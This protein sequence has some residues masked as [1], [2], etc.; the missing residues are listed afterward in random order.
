MADK[1]VLDSRDKQTSKDV[2]GSDNLIPLSPQWVLQKSGENKPGNVTGENNFTV[3]PGYTS[4][5]DGMKSPGNCEEIHDIPKKKDVFRPTVLDMDSGRRD[6]WRDEERDTNFS[7]RRDRWSEGDKDLGDSRKVDRRMDNSSARNFTE[8]R[9]APSDRWTDV[10]NREANH[11]QRRE[12][13][14][15]T[16]WGPDDKEV[17]SLRDKWMDSSR[18]ADIPIVK[19]LSHLTNHGKDEK[20]GDY[21][22]PWRPNAHNRG[23]VEP[24]PHPC[25]TPSRQGS[26]FAYGRGRGENVLPTS[27]YGRGRVGPGGSP[28]NSTSVHPQSFGT[29]SEKGEIGH[30]E[31]SPISYSRTKLLDV[32]RMTDMISCQKIL[33]GVV[34]VPSLTQEE[35]LEP[36]A[37]CAPTADEVVI[38]KGI[39]KGDIVSSEAPQIHKDGSIGRNSNDFVQGRLAKLGSTEDVPPTVDDYK[40]E[41]VD[42][43]KGGHSNQTEGLSYAKQMHSYRP[44]AKVETMQSQQMYSDRKLYPEALREDGARYRTDEA[45]VNRESSVQGNSSIHPGTAWR[46]PS[47]GERT[48]VTSHDRRE[49]PTDVRSRTS[50]IVWLQ[51]QKNLN[52]EWGSGVADLSYPKD[53]SKWQYGEDLITRMKPSA[54]LDRE[55]DTQKLSQPSPEDLLLYYKDPRGEVQGPFTGSDIIGWF[56]AGYFG[57]DL[58]VRLANAPLDSPFSLLGDVMPHL[59]AKTRP[60]PGFS[61]PKQ[62]EIVHESSSS[63]FSA[64]GQ[65]HTSSSEMDMMKAEQ[66]YKHSSAMEAEN[67]FLESLMSGS[68]NPTSNSPLEKFSFTEG[69]QGYSSGIPP[70][71]VESGDNPYLLAK[72]MALEQQRSLPNSYPYWPGRDATPVVPNVDIVHNSITPHSQLLSS[73]G[74]NPRQQPHPQ[75]L[76]S[77]LQGLPDRS[78]SGFNNGGSGRSN[79]SVLGESD[80]LQEKLE[81]HQSQN[82]PPNA[83]FGVQ[84]Q[85]LQPQ[86]QPS[87]TN[88]LAQNLDN[89]SG[90]LTP[91]KLLSSGLSQ[92]PQLLS[93]L[94]QQ[95]LLQL[96]SQAPV[97]S[98]QMSLLDKL[99]LLKQQQK[100][101]EQQQLLRQQQ[102]LLS[103]VLSDHHLHQSFGDQS[104][105]QLQASALPTGNASADHPRLQP[106]QELFQMGSQT[107]VANLQDDHTSNFVNLPPSVLP[108]V[109]HNVGS[110]PASIKLPH[111]MFANTIYKNS[112]GADIQQNNSLLTT[113]ID[114]SLQSELV[115]KSPLEQISQNRLRFNEHVTKSEASVEFVPSEHPGKSVVLESERNFENDV[116]VPEQV[117]ELMFPLTGDLE[118]AQDE[119]E[120]GSEETS[121]V[122]EPK[123][124]EA[125]E[126]RK[127]SEKK[128]KKQRSSKAQSSDQAKGVSETPSLQQSKPSETEVSN[129]ADRKNEMHIGPGE[130]IHGTSPREATES[131]SEVNMVEIGDAQHVL[132]KGA[133]RDGCESVDAK[134]DSRSV[135]DASQLNTQVTGQRAWKPA[136]G[137]KPKSLLDIQQEEQ[138]KAQTEMAISEI[139]TSVDSINFSTPWAGVVYSDHKTDTGSAELSLGKPDSS[140]NKNSKKSQLD[141]LLAEE[142]S[143]KSKERDM[144]VRNSISLS[145][146]NAQLDPVDDDNF[147]EAKDTKKSRKKSAKAKAVAAKAA[148]PTASADVYVGP[149][150]NEKGKGSRQVQ[151]EKEVLPAVPS[152]P[153][154]GDFVIWKGESVNPPPSPAW[155]ADSGKLSK[156][157]SLRDILREQEKK[158]SSVQQQIPIPTKKS[159]PTQ[160]SRESGPSWSLSASSPTKAV[161]PIQIASAQPK[162]KGDDDLFWGPLDQPK[163]D[164]KQSEFPHL[165]SQGSLGSKSSP[166]KGTFGGSLSRQKSTASRPAERYLS[167]SPAS[168]QPSL[169]EKKHAV[170]KHSE[171]MDFRDWCESETVRLT[172]TKDTSFLEFCLKQSRSEAEILLTENLS[173]YDPAHEFIDKF[174][175]YK[176]LLP[177]DVLEIA[178]Q[179][180][181]DRKATTVFGARDM[182]SENAGV[183]ESSYQVN[184]MGVDG[185]KGGGKKKGKKGKKVSPSVL[186]FNVVSNRIMMGEIQT[187]ED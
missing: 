18:D 109:S 11:D 71:G 181:N 3:S 157:A 103:Q 117:N 91:E 17:D 112:L 23:R 27:L 81:L 9:R 125:H 63:N 12:S 90:I 86:N 161:S 66:R 179:G 75:N 83:A 185:S 101:E 2:H 111:H 25:S 163:Q 144:E 28:M 85:R 139:S 134:G 108:D 21:Y 16:R 174:L 7:V 5:S 51:S 39:D 77:I 110:G 177:A 184:P 158:A 48:N 1:T 55:Q 94:Q 73:I 183:G 65:L 15:N 172:G 31:P 87:L 187:V 153:S 173:A 175:N 150:F 36:L 121:M 160:S 129:V 104:Y 106:S 92:D 98:Q 47:I 41:N 35:P 40:G 102:Q 78:T 147:I 141:D 116:S 32:Y 30:G 166:A 119:R 186:G 42:N 84:Q 120:R 178:F 164:V 19:G 159:Q 45:A 96:H 167:S 6:R 33:D 76:M 126:G 4:L 44:D 168:A 74:D 93:L 140:L 136:P 57:I 67:K 135:G 64:H 24:P 97:P 59:R 100:Q 171:A 143:A 162:H 114:S 20:E 152:G 118:K 124:V 176:E 54:V 138:R 22:R 170:T 180:R 145:V 165:S 68:V 128:S 113:V 10:S 80:T 79:F 53:E 70:L 8:A 127:G 169:K 131:K 49:I 123:H 46:S 115:V 60:P 34:P 151:L 38:L 130:I 58:Q 148:V 89:S 146:V 56:E 52:N 149:S 105:G 13:K 26:T 37:F 61:A 14:W 154:L 122:K 82:F 132:S 69:L 88:L 155:S 182:N 29:T 99:L 43:S 72:R 142:V 50:D 107:P 156:A 137:F 95:Y 62:N 133:F